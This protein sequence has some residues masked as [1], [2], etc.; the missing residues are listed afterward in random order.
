VSKQVKVFLIFAVL[1]L[2]G[3]SYLSLTTQ[4]Y[5]EQV[6]ETSK[7]ESHFKG[8]VLQSWK[9]GQWGL[10]KTQSITRDGI[11]HLFDSTV[12]K[13]FL[14]IVIAAKEGNDFWVE[15]SV[16]ANNEEQQFSALITEQ[17]S[18]QQVKYSVRALKLPQK[19]SIVLLTDALA[20]QDQAD[21][22][23]EQVQL[24]LHLLS[25]SVR[26]G[27]QRNVSVPAGQLAEANEVPITL[28]LLLG[29]MQGYVWMHN[30]VPI[31]PV[32]KV[33]LNKQTARW[34]NTQKTTVLVDFGDSGQARY[35]AYD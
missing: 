8:E 30:A 32:V 35:F 13:G 10:Y 19:Q 34:F 9:V 16:V 21:E 33:E 24:W 17:I 12:D 29:Q 2:M 25:Y 14:K 22:Q 4:A 31:F 27:V 3:C 23:Y 28:S 6:H 7:L 1:N 11:F 15:F 20:M 18:E 5:V 26:E